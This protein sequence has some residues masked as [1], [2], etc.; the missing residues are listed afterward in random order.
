[1]EKGEI[2]VPVEFMTIHEGQSEFELF[3]PP[4]D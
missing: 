1:M 2:G 3:T 4:D